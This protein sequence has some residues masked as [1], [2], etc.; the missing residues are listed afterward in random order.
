ME[1]DQYPGWELVSGDPRRRP[2]WRHIA[3]NWQNPSPAQEECRRKFGAFASQTKGV[4]GT[5]PLPDGRIL[6]AS[7]VEISKALSPKSCIEP[8]QN[9]IIEPA[10]TAAAAPHDESN[11]IDMPT[12]KVFVATSTPAEP[13]NMAPLISLYRDVEEIRT[14]K[15]HEDEAVLQKFNSDLRTE[16][17]QLKIDFEKSKAA[18]E[19]RRRHTEACIREFVDSP[20]SKAEDVMW[21]RLQTQIEKIQHKLEDTIPPIPASISVSSQPAVPAASPARSEADDFSPLSFLGWTIGA[22]SA[23]GL[24]AWGLKSKDNMAA[25]SDIVHTVNVVLNP[26][27]APPSNKP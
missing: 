25:V 24:I 2:Y 13:S 26:R 15:R 22:V 7:A 20:H 14:M 12:E 10:E 5:T 17:E 3:P 23:A 19:E 16:R 9:D 18:L 8:L 11:H 6:S 21:S 1:L 27:P 4:T